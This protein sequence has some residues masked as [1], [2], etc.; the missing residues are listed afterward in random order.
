MQT[1][2]CATLPGLGDLPGPLEVMN[3]LTSGQSLC[4]VPRP[5]K[6]W[7]QRFHICQ[8]LGQRGRKRRHLARHSICPAPPAPRDF[9]SVAP[10][11]QDSGPAR[12]AEQALRGGKQCDL[13]AHT[14]AH[15]CVCTHTRT[16][17]QTQASHVCIQ[18]LKTGFKGAD[19]SW[20]GD[21]G[22]VL[23]LLQRL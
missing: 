12:S 22:Q 3:S 19:V 7:G 2:V 20:Q 10:G 13:K 23:K 14:C 5:L 9:R 6:G 1:P 18:A 8:D 21:F 16:L 4:R 15:I 17:M 11:R